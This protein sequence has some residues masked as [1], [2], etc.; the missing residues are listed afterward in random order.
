MQVDMTLYVFHNLL[1]RKAIH[2]NFAKLQKNTYVGVSLF[3]E[4][5]GCRTVTLTKKDKN[6]NSNLGGLFRGSF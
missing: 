4:G 3:N 5:A 2:E 6:F 1:C